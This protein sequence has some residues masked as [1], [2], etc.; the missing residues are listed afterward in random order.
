MNKSVYLPLI[1][2]FVS[3][4]LITHSHAELCYEAAGYTDED[5]DAAL[6]A[7]P[8][9]GI[10]HSHDTYGEHT[11]EKWVR[12]VELPAGCLHIEHAGSG[13]PEVEIET[14]TETEPPEGYTTLAVLTCIAGSCLDDPIQVIGPANIDGNAP[15]KPKLGEPDL[16]YPTIEIDGVNYWDPSRDPIP[17]PTSE[18]AENTEGEDPPTRQNPVQTTATYNGAPQSFEVIT[19]ASSNDERF[20][21]DEEGM[22]IPE[23]E[24]P[25]EY[26]HSGQWWRLSSSVVRG[27]G[28][29]TRQLEIISVVEVG[30]PRRLIVTLRNHTKRFIDLTQG[31]SLILSRPDGSSATAN[32]RSRGSLLITPQKARGEKY[33]DTEV[34]LLPWKLVRKLDRK[35]SFYLAFQYFYGSQSGYK[36]GD[37]FI[38]SYEETEVSR[39]PEA[40][41]AAPRL[42]RNMVTTWGSLK[43]AQ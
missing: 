36:P 12:R 41:S 35:E 14:E 39:Y 31:W 18:D 23:S 6:E 17:I 8:W 34:T 25:D 43:K 29:G 16:F 2:L 21:I 5:I 4:V 7:A 10:T 3:V 22:A 19:E 20:V 37:V 26:Q 9:E 38:L 27:A 30:S 42:N 24:L 15:P 11:H 13:H 40:L 28:S 32:M 33:A 1:L